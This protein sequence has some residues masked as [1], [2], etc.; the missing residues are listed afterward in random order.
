MSIQDSIAVTLGSTVGAGGSFSFNYPAGRGPN[1][2]RGGANGVITSNSSQTLI[3]NI[4]D[5]SVAYGASQATVT[6]L[7]GRGFTAGEVIT[8]FLDRATID[9][10]D[11]RV[12]ANPAKMGLLSPVRVILGAPAAASANA[13]CLSQ[14]LNTGATALLNGATAGVLDVPRALVAAWTN[15]AV[16]TV[17]GLDE[18]GVVVRESSASGTTFAGRKAFSR[19]TSVTVSANVTGLTVGTS[20][21][22]GLPVFLPNGTEIIREI[23]DDAVAVAGTIN[24]GDTTTPSATT[25]DV[26]GTY[27]PNSAPNGTLRFSLI[28]MLRNPEFRG[29]PQFAG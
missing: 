3:Q 24:A 1:D 15:I 5:Y 27:A 18:F 7:R 12:M 11:T 20:A 4:G 6:V 13:I 10:S 25:G 26:R 21:I 22:L 29:G 17:T 16:L 14:A 2:Y 19:I 8:V 9:G 23:Q 28:A